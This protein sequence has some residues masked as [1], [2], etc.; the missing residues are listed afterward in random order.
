M[1]LPGGQRDYGRCFP[2]IGPLKSVALSLG[3]FSS[4]LLV[5]TI[6]FVLIYLPHLSKTTGEAKHTFLDKWSNI[7]LEK[8][9]YFVTIVCSS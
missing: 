2:G 6:V 9:R 7:S 3:L 8:N 4:L 1:P 5:G